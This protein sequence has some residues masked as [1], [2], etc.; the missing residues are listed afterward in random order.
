VTVNEFKVRS[1]VRV[2]AA[3]TLLE[4]LVA[5]AIIAVLAALIVP[6][7]SRA[8]Y[9]AR[10]T[11][12]KNNIRQLSLA[13]NL[14]A[15]MHEYLPPHT[16][17]GRISNPG[18]LQDPSRIHWYDLLDLPMTWYEITNGIRASYLGGVFDCPF[19]KGLE[20]TG[21]FIPDQ[22]KFD[23]ERKSDSAY[24]YNAWGVGLVADRLG[25][26][27]VSD[28]TLGPALEAAKDSSIRV[29]SQM[30]AFGDKFHRSIR[31]ELDAAQPTTIVTIAPR[32]EGY[33]L[34]KA[35]IRPFKLQKSFT[36]HRGRRHLSFYDGHVEVEDM[37]ETF[38]PSD[39]DLRRWNSDHE[40]HRKMLRP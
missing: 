18:P 33:P 13:L 12:C 1:F 7:L 2:P 40:P 31:P 37:R 28:S 22:S 21:T 20:G 29:P 35:G 26:G 15:T 11:V 27:G 17:A 32:T 30:I 5:I 23:F 6:A 39:D 4:L 10:N 3:F 14:Y 19:N 38:Q 24:G 16:M 34:S 8:K 9:Y 36:G 25:L